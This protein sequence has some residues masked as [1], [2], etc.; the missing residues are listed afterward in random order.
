MSAGRLRPTEWRAGT[1]IVIALAAALLV[2]SLVLATP[3]PLFLAFPLLLAPAAAALEA[4]R[5]ATAVAVRWSVEGS[6]SEVTIR[7]VVTP[8]PEIPADSIDLTFYRPPPLREAAPPEV[9]R[10]GAELHFV[11]RWE[12]PYPCLATVP[13]PE[14]VW[15][16]PLGF[17]ERRL[18][19]DGETLHVERFP[20]ELTRIGTVRLRR[21]TPLPGEVRSKALGASGEFFAIRP[22]TP[23]DTPRQ[24]NWWASART[25]RLLAN[26][27]LQE[28]TGDLLILLDLRPSPLRD[29]RDRTMLTIAKAAALGIAN[30]FSNEKARVG[31][32]MF[33]EFLTAVPLGSGRLQRYR[34]ARALER[35]AVAETPGPSERFAVSLA[36]YFPPGVT[37]VLLSPLAD[38]E[39]LLLLSHLRHRGFPAFVLS[40]SPLPL[41]GPS[42]ERATG[43][44]ALAMRLL[45]LVRR[46]RVNRAWQEAPVVE[47]PD[48]WSLA[49]L[50]RYLKV[51]PRNARRAS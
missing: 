11:L 33:D 16:D 31:L 20:P 24:V 6:T 14:V 3:V 50:V 45:S 29:R 17:L 22:A 34:I 39:P 49:P 27:Y 1:L 42:S 46:R 30:G 28:R 23:S 9:R 21:T 38:E 51:P 43:D 7:G 15:R 5:P 35:A 2:A 25:G 18:Q 12:A 40:P 32:G 8:P 4:P 26:D 19:V 41:L 48:Y 36:R 37:T 44:D 47:W 13:W 10:K